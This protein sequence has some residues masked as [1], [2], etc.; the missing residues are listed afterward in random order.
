VDA[1]MR[2]V[3]STPKKTSIVR[4]GALSLRMGVAGIWSLPSGPDPSG[5]ARSNPGDQPV[6]NVIEFYV[7]K[8]FRKQLKWVSPQQRG[9][10][11]EFYTPAKKSA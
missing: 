6:A 1:I 5:Y 7:P 2:R 11:I 9:K 8:A 4:F 10:V 3:Q